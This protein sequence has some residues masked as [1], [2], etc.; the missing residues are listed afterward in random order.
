M[1]TDSGTGKSVGLHTLARRGTMT[2]MTAM[3]VAAVLTFAAGAA[4]VWAL[5]AA[6]RAGSL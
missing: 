4:A 1:K 6:A 3:L 5:V 2:R